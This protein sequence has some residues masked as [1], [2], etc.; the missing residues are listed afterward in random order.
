MQLHSM[1]F[2]THVFYGMSMRH[3]NLARP[4]KIQGYEL[5]IRRQL[6][7]GVGVSSGVSAR[8]ASGKVLAGRV[9][10]RFSHNTLV[11]NFMLRIALQVLVTL[12][13]SITADF[14]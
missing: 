14:S 9:V 12:S 1:Y 7:S 4:T 13:F 2:T 6:V 10:F 8:P 3:W 11:Y 5:K